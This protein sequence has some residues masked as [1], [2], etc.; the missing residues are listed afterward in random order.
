MRTV[1]HSRGRF[2]S[3]G[4]GPPTIHSAD[5]CA[6]SREKTMRAS[7]TFEFG[8]RPPQTHRIA[9]VQGRSPGTVARRAIEEAKRVL[10]PVGWRSAVVLLERDD[11]HE[12]EQG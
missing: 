8:A 3:G 11:Q 2:S 7:I 9:A 1:Q 4:K 12:P 10:A 6:D 5:R